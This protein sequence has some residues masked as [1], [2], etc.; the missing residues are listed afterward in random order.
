VF[1]S[2]RGTPLKVENVRRRVLAPVAEEVGAPWAGFH[3]FRHTC[4]SLLFENG[5]NAKQVQKW[6]GH[7]SPSFTIDTYVHLLKD[8][9]DEPLELG[10]EL[11]SVNKVQTSG[12][13]ALP[14]EAPASEHGTRL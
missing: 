10:I 12:G 3:T 5:K 4:A 8:E 14:E 6:L 1:P 7:H 9:L 2:L 13:L 11:G